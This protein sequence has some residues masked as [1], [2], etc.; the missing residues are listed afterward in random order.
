MTPKR[1]APVVARRLVERP[2]APPLPPVAVL[3]EDVPVEVLTEE[4]EE[5]R[6]ET[7]ERMLEWTLETLERTE[8]RTEETLVA[9]GRVEEAPQRDA[10][11]DWASVI[12]S[13][14]QLASRHWRT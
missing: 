8:D 2:A 6:E 5:A 12:S 3:V 13:A 9:E 7:L 11:R 10:W 14:V 4:R 1:T